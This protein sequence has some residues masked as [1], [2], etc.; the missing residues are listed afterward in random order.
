MLVRDEKAWDYAIGMLRVDGLEPT[1]EMM[2]MIE[3]ENTG[4]KQYTKQL[5]KLLDIGILKG[6]RQILVL[7]FIRIMEVTGTLEGLA[8]L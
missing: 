2:E 1:L 6:K 4:W 3:R 5:T 7:L 8:V